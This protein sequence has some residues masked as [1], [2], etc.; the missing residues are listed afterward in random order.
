M[1]LKLHSSQSAVDTAS[2]SITRTKRITFAVILGMLSAIGPFSLDMYLPALPG[3][4]NLF[5]TSASAVQLSLTACML[6]LALGQIFAGPL[7]DMRGRRGPLIA[8]LSVYA[9]T[10]LLCALS[11]NVGILVALRLLQGLSGAAGI[12]ISRAVV[13]DLFSGS[14]MTR[15]FSQLML[16]NGAAPI[17]APVLGGQFL[18]FVS[19]RGVFVFLFVLGLALTLAVVWAL[20]ETLPK[21]RRQSGGLKKTLDTFKNFG[22]D[23]LFMGYVLAL[24]LVSAGMFGYISGSSFVLQNLYHVSEQGYSLIFAMNGLGI[25]LASQITGRLAAKFDIGRLF[26]NGLGV[27]MTGGA[28]LLLSV[29]LDGGLVFIVISL[30]LVVSSVGIVSTT[31]SSLALQNAGKAAGSASA[32]L[33]LLQFVLGAVASPLV[34][35]GGSNTAL[36]MA[37]TIFSAEIL[38][39]LICF[40]LVKGRRKAT[41]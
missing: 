24:G 35:L 17:I 31:A 10:S 33:G 2:T 34:G 32:L 25:I 19:W 14:E 38:A 26:L 16:I 12:V 28:A 15:F 5:H 22:S 11:P 8:A 21:D 36:P 23:R 37:V 7:S 40:I 6:G 39:V 29:L 9:I 4:A 13:R 1:N 18:R 30:F 41:E 20:P 27:A 3:M